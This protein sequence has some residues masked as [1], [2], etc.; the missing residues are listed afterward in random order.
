MSSL[1]QKF[2]KPGN[3]EAK[4]EFRQCKRWWSN[5]LKAQNY[6]P[7]PPL[8]WIPQGGGECCW[9]SSDGDDPRIIWGLKFSI[10]GFFWVGKF[11]K[12]F[13]VWPDLSR[14][15]LGVSLEALG[16]FLVFNICPIRSSL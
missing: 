14:D 15:F 6:H 11:G 3:K 9:I 7:T 16:I 4:Y 2:G 13:F 5:G 8:Q 12:Y 1:H 10:T